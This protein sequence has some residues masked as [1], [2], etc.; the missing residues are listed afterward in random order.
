MG[1]WT[2]ATTATAVSMVKIDVGIIQTTTYDTRLTQYVEAAR[3]ELVREG[4]SDLSDD[5]GDIQLV[6]G[7]AA[8]AWRKRDTGEGLPEYLRLMRNNRI[9]SAKMKP[10][11]ATSG[12][13]AAPEE[14]PAAEDPDPAEAEEAEEG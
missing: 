11:A 1:Q 3:G 6:A 4:L 13:D 2:N 5:V 8:W 7:F 9:F 10:A 14:T 12:P